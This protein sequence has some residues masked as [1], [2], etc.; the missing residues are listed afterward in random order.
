LVKRQL[1]LRL[2]PLRLRSLLPIILRVLPL[3][4]LARCLAVLLVVKAVLQVGRLLE[5]SLE[6]HL[7]QRSG[8][9]LAELQ[10]LRA[11]GSL[12]M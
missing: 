1:Q 10:V 2:L 11:V 5:R 9:S 7:E 4:S 12:A 8:L 6:G 3:V